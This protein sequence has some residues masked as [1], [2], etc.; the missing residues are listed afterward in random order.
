M[1]RLVGV[2]AA[3]KQIETSAFFPAL[4]RRRLPDRRQPHRGG[5]RQSRR[6]FL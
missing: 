1:R 2:E 6:V 5:R 3:V 4:A